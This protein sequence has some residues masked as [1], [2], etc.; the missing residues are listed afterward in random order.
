MVGS[1]QK[2][3]SRL[4]K[5]P[6]FSPRQPG[7]PYRETRSKSF[8]KGLQSEVTIFT[9]NREKHPFS[10]LFRSRGPRFGVQIAR[11]S[12]RFFDPNTGLRGF[13]LPVF[14][15]FGP[16]LRSASLSTIHPSPDPP[17]PAATYIS[18]PPTRGRNCSGYPIA[19]FDRIRKSLERESALLILSVSLPTPIERWLRDTIQ[20]AGLRACSCSPG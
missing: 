15:P 3:S 11:R 18:I 10:T 9:S 1:Y 13:Q 5:P 4:S 20:S 17:S 14:L 7:F 6:R 16:P 12:I 19:A 2:A 8:P